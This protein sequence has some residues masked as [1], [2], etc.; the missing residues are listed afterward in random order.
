MTT[1]PK[2]LHVSSGSRRRFTV[3]G[4]DRFNN[5]GVD[6]V[7][8]PDSVQ[9]RSAV[10]QLRPDDY[11]QTVVLRGYAKPVWHSVGEQAEEFTPDSLDD[12]LS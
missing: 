3:F 12:I 5:Q 7:S 4:I 1:P 11:I 8:A 9:A 2:V 10:N 6:Y